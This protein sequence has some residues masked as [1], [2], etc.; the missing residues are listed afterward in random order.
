[1]GWAYLAVSLV[2]AWFTVNAY[3]PS[4]RWQVLALSFFAGWLTSELAVFHIAWQVAASVGFIWLGALESWPGI[5]GLVIT[6]ASW[7]GLVGLQFV[8]RRSAQ[9]IEDALREGL[10]HDYR[11][12]I[13]P[14]LAERLARR[15]SRRHLLLPFY[16]RDRRVRRVKNIQYAPGG[17][18]RHLLDVWRPKGDVERAPVLFQIHGGAWMVGDK[19][20]QAL[21]LMLHLAAEGW[22]CVAANYRLSPRVSFPDHLIDNKLALRWI[23][24]HISEYGGDPDFVVVTGGSAGG[25]LAALLALT[26]DDPEFQPG[27]E[28]VDTSVTACVPVYGVYDLV[29]EFDP[30]GRA[31]AHGERIG[32]W[33]GRR[34]V[35][36]SIDEDRDRF[37]RM[38]PISHVGPHAPP[39]F[40][41]HGTSDNLVTVEQARRFV[42]ALRGASRKPVLYA[43]IPGASH[44]FEVFHSVRTENVVN[45]I[46]R[47]LAWL[48]SAHQARRPDVPADPVDPRSAAAATARD[49]R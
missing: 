42:A 40:V 47:F 1:M 18:R 39:F 11:S 6:L 14:G 25:H 20:Q 22:V 10:G 4:R 12:E 30:R 33:M 44:A 5:V 9:V 26:P 38:S 8:S 23:R 2:G 35:G 19:G 13:A 27:F 21:P 16:L 34:I 48:H 45:G 24:E 41:V 3:W 28:D 46:D 15:T 32:Q 36:A 17:G 49:R 37:V 31:G 7:A 43:E 29:E